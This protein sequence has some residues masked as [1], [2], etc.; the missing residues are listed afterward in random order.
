MIAAVLALANVAAPSPSV[1]MS[2]LLEARLMLGSTP[3]PRI[4]LSSVQI[5]FP[6]AGDPTVQVVVKA[7]DTTVAEAPMTIKTRAGNLAVAN[8]KDAGFISLGTTPGPREITVLVDGKPA[9]RLPFTLNRKQSGDAL[10]PSTEYDVVGP[11]KDYAYLSY[12]A[13]SDGRNDINAVYWVALSEVGASAKPTVVMTIRQGTKLIA[14]GGERYP[15]GAGYSR[16]DQPFRTPDNQTFSK[17]L[18]AKLNGVLTFEVKAGTKVLRKWDVQVANGDF[19]PHVRSNPETT[20]P[21]KFLA[22]RKIN[23]REISKKVMTWLAAP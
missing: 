17:Q 14:S 2:S 5:A 18:L 23:G 9:G 8:P 7:G 1:V 3:E 20:D 12:D 19:V 10:A 13:V 6:P 22:S 11:W 15:N 4:H 16:F 21:L